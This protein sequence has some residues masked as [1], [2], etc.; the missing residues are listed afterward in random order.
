MRWLMTL[1]DFEDDV[2]IV[3]ALDWDGSQAAVTEITRFQPEASRAVYS[4]GF[5]G[6]AVVPDG[7][8]VCGFNAV[9][10]VELS[11]GQVETVLM[12]DDFNDLHHV[13]AHDGKLWVVNTGQ[14]RVEA[15][16]PNGD[17]LD[18]WSLEPHQGAH[19]QSASDPYFAG[20][21][22]DIPLYRRRLMDLVH[23]NGLAFGTGQIL[24]TRFSD[25]AVEELLSGRRVVPATPGCPH[26]PYFVD[27]EL[28]L[29][30]TNGLI[31]RYAPAATGYQER[32]RFNVFAASGQLGWCRGLHVGPE[33][34]AVGLTRI[35]RMPRI[36]WGDWPFEL[37]RTG[38]ALLDRASGQ[39]QAWIDL[40]AWGKHPKLFSILPYPS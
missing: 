39:L 6:G 9:Y 30:C 35:T 34:L 31:V 14:D 10:R 17:R 11:S 13:A 8:L 33:L 1:G 18:V 15:F 5:T 20:Q 16:G 23:P 29:T 24:V 22:P 32:Q 21:T 7:L 36:R 25:N 26:D 19:S 4:K 37:T 40:G 28:W 27:D 3:L 2:G 38:V 12:R